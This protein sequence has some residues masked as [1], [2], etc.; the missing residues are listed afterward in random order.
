MRSQTRKIRSQKELPSAVEHDH[1]VK[2]FCGKIIAE[3]TT[4]S[5]NRNDEVGFAPSRAK[6]EMPSG[7]A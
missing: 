5:E 3:L 2:P 7:I 4:A 6:T 1:L